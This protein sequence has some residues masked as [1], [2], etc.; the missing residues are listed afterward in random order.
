MNGHLIFPGQRVTMNGHRIFPCVA[1]D[2]HGLPWVCDG[3]FYGGHI[4]RVA[5]ACAV[6]AHTV[7]AVCALSSDARR[8]WSA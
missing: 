6:L 4:S 7:T 1:M 8:A 2:L 3:V 5:A